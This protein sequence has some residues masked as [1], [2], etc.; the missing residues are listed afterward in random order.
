MENKIINMKDYKRQHD[1]PLPKSPYYTLNAKDY[2]IQI[3]L[4]RAAEFMQE[5]H[6]YSGKPQYAVLIGYENKKNGKVKLLKQQICFPSEKAFETACPGINGYYCLAL[7][8]RA[9]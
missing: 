7:K 2:E 3:A 5:A 9:E 6:D 4:E 8:Q 1:I